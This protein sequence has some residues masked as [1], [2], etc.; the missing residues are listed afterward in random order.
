VTGLLALVADLLL[1][2]LGAVAGDV[3]LLAAVEA[4]G[5][6][7]ALAGEVTLW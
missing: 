2:S 3:S 1:G 7:H 5:G 4:L 6:V